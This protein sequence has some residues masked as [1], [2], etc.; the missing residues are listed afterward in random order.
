MATIG[1]RAKEKG[2]SLLRR[3]SSWRARSG[4]SIDAPPV[5][6]R[7]ANIDVLFFGNTND[8]KDAY[9]DD[10]RATPRRQLPA[11]THTHTHTHTHTRRPRRSH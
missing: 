8:G 3:M 10:V 5:A 1:E 11:Y 6:A 2:V 4:F 9:F 7:M